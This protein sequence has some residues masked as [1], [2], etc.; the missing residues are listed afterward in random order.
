MPWIIVAIGAIAAAVLDR[1]AAAAQSTNTLAQTLV[2]GAVVLGTLYVV[3][4]MAKVI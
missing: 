2:E 3:A 1:E 4:K